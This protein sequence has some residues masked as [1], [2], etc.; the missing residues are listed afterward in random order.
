MLRFEPRNRAGAAPIGDLSQ[1]LSALL[2]ARGIEDPE[3]IRDF[4]Q[5]D[6]RLDPVRSCSD[7]F[8]FCKG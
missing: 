3:E 5:L 1:T 7:E 8:V 2:R 6:Y 4:D